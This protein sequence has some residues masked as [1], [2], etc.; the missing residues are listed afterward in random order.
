MST[1]T[2]GFARDSRRRVHMVN[3]P[4]ADKPRLRLTRRGRAFVLALALASITVVVIALGPSGVATAESAAPG[5]FTTVTVLP[6]QT[7]WDIAATANPSGDIR[8]TVDRIIRLNALESAGGLQMGAEL[9][10]P[11]YR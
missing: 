3:L 10:V 11:V 5:Q 6:G 2:Y 4:V 1:V 8:D 9:A 7:I